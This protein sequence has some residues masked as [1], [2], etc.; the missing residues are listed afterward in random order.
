M[1]Q[2]IKVFSYLV[3]QFLIHNPF[4]NIVKDPNTATIVN[5]ICGGIFI[6]IV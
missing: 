4:S 1:Y 6:P 5:R 3:R 2:L